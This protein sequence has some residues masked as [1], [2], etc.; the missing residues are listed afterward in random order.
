LAFENLEHLPHCAPQGP[1][2]KFIGEIG[3]EAEAI[4]RA[5]AEMSKKAGVELE[6]AKLQPT[7]SGPP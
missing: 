6:F 1:V 4:K 7:I 2:T 5:A 3:G